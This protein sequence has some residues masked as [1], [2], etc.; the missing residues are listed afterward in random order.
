VEAAYGK[1]VDAEECT[2][3]QRVKKSKLIGFAHGGK[4]QREVI[5]GSM[6]K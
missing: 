4:I 3:G 2:G 1:T 6:L 5:T